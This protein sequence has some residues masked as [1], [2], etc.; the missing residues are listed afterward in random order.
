MLGI[1]LA[2]LILATCGLAGI[3]LLAMKYF[4]YQGTGLDWIYPAAGLLIMLW[5][6]SAFG[7]IASGVTALIGIVKSNAA[8]R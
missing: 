6:L 4:S 8:R 5:C 1:S 2:A 7:V 3:L